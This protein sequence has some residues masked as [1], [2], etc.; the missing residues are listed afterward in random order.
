MGQ[1]KKGNY[2][3]TDNLGT[4]TIT[5]NSASVTLTAPSDSKTYDGTALTA[6]GTGEKKVTASG[7][8]SGFTVEATASGSQTDA[9]ESANVVNDGYVIRNAAGE[10]KTASF[11]N[12]AKVDGKLTVNPKA[13]TITT[14]S[15]SK[16]YDGTPLTKAEANIEGLVEG[17]SVTLAATGTITEEGSTENTYSITWDNARKATT[18]SLTIWVL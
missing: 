18:Q 11:T 5:K 7:L 8:P 13:V 4:L 12:V 14:G 16:P 9:G 2:T 15:D 1:R 17:E 3:V 6:D 10:D